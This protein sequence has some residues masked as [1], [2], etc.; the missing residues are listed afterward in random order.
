MNYEQQYQNEWDQ[1]IGFGGE[2][3]FRPTP[4]TEQ[5]IAEREVSIEESIAIEMLCKDRNA[6]AVYSWA[7]QYVQQVTDHNNFAELLSIDVIKKMESVTD[8]VTR[9]NGLARLYLADA[10]VRH[11]LTGFSG[12]TNTTH[13]GFGI[14]ITTS[15]AAEIVNYHTRLQYCLTEDKGDGKDV[16]I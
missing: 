4:R 5:Q 9:D 8:R 13:L 2:G 1:F 12:S 3:H 10:I 14:S 7:E 16:D 11:R 6:S 15:L